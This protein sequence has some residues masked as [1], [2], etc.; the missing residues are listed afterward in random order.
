MTTIEQRDIQKQALAALQAAL[1][2][3]VRAGLKVEIG[4]FFDRPDPTVMIVISPVRED[5]GWLLLADKE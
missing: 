3:C 5:A 4:V 1:S 2:E